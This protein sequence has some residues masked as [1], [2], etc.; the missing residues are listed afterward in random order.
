MPNADAE[1]DSNDLKLIIKQ[2]KQKSPY[3]QRIEIL[4][5]I[6]KG[7][8]GSIYKVQDA[9]GKFHA[10]KCIRMDPRPPA[11]LSID[12]R[13]VPATEIRIL[14]Q[15]NYEQIPWVP[16]LYS[17]WQTEHDKEICYFQHMELFDT[18]LFQH[19]LWHPITKEIYMHPF[20]IAIELGMKGIIHGDLQWNQF[21]LQ[22]HPNKS[23]KRMVLSDFG[24]GSNVLLNAQQT[25]FIEGFTC[26]VW[27]LGFFQYIDDPQHV[28]KR[29][30]FAV[31]INCQQLV[32][33][34]LHTRRNT[35]L[36]NKNTWCII[37]SFSFGKYQSIFESLIAPEQLKSIQEFYNKMM[38]EVVILAESKHSLDKKDSSKESKDTKSETFKVQNVHCDFSDYLPKKIVAVLE[39][40]WKLRSTTQSMQNLSLSSSLPSSSVFC[41]KT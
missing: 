31:Y 35:Y 4:C 29:K 19:E 33:S 15:L 38:P 32:A 36:L 26:N 21:L 8:W 27:K 7:N 41:V 40:E 1:K 16:K 24:F 12:Y 28:L 14:Q 3:L 37:E 6:G 2:E 20:R 34:L 5:L 18:D 23:I 39:E 22:L 13:Q 30:L 25:L 9:S 17:S 11:L 10:L